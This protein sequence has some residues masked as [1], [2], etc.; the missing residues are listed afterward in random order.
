MP[1]RSQKPL[2]AEDKKNLLMLLEEARSRGIEVPAEAQQALQ[3]KKKITWPLASNGYFLRNDGHLYIP[4]PEQEAFIKSNARFVLFYGSRGSGKTA[5]GAQKA[6]MKIMMGES[7]IIMNPDFENLKFS[8]WLEFRNWIPWN[9][10]VP[11]QRHRAHPEWNPTQPFAMIFNNGASVYLKGGKESHSSRGRNANWFWYDEGG[12]DEDGM[13][14]RITN[15]S[16]R[17]GKLAPQSWCTETPR[18]TEHWSYKF[19]IEKEIPQEAID[20]FEKVYGSDRILVEAFH[21]TIAQNKDN[22]SPSF[23]ADV[24]ANYPSGYLR[25]QEV[26]GEFANEGGKIGDRAWFDGKVLDESPE[27]VLKKVRFWDLAATEK[28]MVGK[29][30]ELND[31]DETVGTL[32]SKYISDDKKKTNFCIE[33]QV[34][35]WWSWDDLLNAIANTARRDGPYVTVVLEEEPGS[36]GKNQVAAVK[37]HFKRFPELSSIKVVGQKAREVGDRVMAANHWFAVAADGRMYMIKGEWNGKFLGQLDGFTQVLHDDRVTSIT[38]A[39][40]YLSP[41][42]AWVKTSFLS[43]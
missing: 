35:G 42:K 15:A 21:G 6:L 40:N 4:H 5:A 31:P 37:T 3:D 34:A 19:F 36:G 8:T 14:W 28:K 11:S 24:L 10:V 25:A 23:Y 22:L 20:E 39:M 18:P 17:I 9:M 38:G 41:F 30:S 27:R 26:D 33:N 16:V 7:G 2:T 43:L 29:K 12:R 13:T 32:M 1:I